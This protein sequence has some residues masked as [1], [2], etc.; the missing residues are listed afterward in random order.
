MSNRSIQENDNTLTAADHAVA[1]ATDGL[2][3]SKTQDIIHGQQNLK[4]LLLLKTD[5]GKVKDVWD[6][7]PL[8]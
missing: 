6:E 4:N 8:E 3:D 5:Y 2:F 7:L 1:L